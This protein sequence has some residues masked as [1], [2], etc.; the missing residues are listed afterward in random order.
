MMSVGLRGGVGGVGIEFV[1]Y[2]EVNEDCIVQG[3]KIGRGTSTS[4]ITMCTIIT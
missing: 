4:D 3:R 1:L 2:S